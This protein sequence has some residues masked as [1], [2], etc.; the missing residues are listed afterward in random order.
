MR[1]ARTLGYRTVAVYSATPMPERRMWPWPTRRYASAPHPRAESYLNVA[2]ILDAARRTGADAVHPGYGFLSENATFAQACV[3]AGLVFIGPPP[4][5]IAAMG[6]KAGAK[7]RM[8]AAGV[9]TV[10]GY[11]GDDQGD[12]R[13]MPEAETL[14]FP[15]LVKAVAG[16]GGRG[17]RLVRASTELQPGIDGARREALSAFGD[18][19]LML[20]RLIPEGR[21]IEIQVFADAHGHAV[22]LGERD[23]T[24]Q[25]RRQKVIEEAPSP[26]VTAAMRETMGRDAVAAALAV[27]YRG[28]GTVE[29]I[30]DADLKH[31]FLEMNTR[32]QVEHPV[33]E[34]ITGLDLVEWQLRVAA[35]EAL[36]LRQEQIRFDGHAIEARLYAEDPYAGFAPQTGA[37]LHFRPAD[38]LRPGIRIDAGIVEGG[39]VTP[40]YDPMLAKVVA[41]GRNRDDAIRRLIAALEDAPLLGV[42]NNGR[43][44][45][46]LL[47]HERFRSATMHT[48]LLDEWACE[49]TSRSCSARSRRR[50]TGN[51]AAALF[52]GPAR[53]AR[54]QRCGLRPDA[55][56]RRRNAKSSSAPALRVR[57][58][59]GAIA[60]HGRLR[61]TQ[62]GITRHATLHR[63]GDTLH[64]ARD[65]AVF[66]FREA[67]PLPA[68]DNR[69]DPA[70]ARA[71][72]AGTVARLEVGAGDTVI[73]GQTL[74]V[75]E[76]MKMEMR[77]TARAAGTVAAVRVLAGSQVEAGAILI[78][79]DIEGSPMPAHDKAILT[80]ALTGVLTDPTQHPVPVTPEADGRL[81]ARGLQCRRQHH[82]CASAPAG[83]LGKGHLPSWDP[84]VAA[85]I[86]DAIRAACPGVIINL[87]TGVIGADISGPAACIRRVKPE[88]A[89]CNAG[90]LNYLKLRDDGR[91]AWPPMVFDNPVEKVK[92]F[93]DVMH[94]TGT[95]PEFECFDVGIVRSVAM[96]QK[97]GMTHHAD[98][99]FVM[100]VASGMPADADLLQLLLR[101]I[102]PG[103]HWQTTL[104]GRAEIWPLHQ[105]T[106]ELG[107]MLRTGP[108]RHASYLPD[109]SRATG[110]GAL[111]EALAAC[112]RNA[113]R[114]VASPAEARRWPC[115]AA[116]TPFA[117]N[118]PIGKHRLWPHP[119]AVTDLAADGSACSMLWF[120]A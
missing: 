104:I 116:L 108:R 115:A 33:T 40:W 31:H 92:A 13:L 84:E 37:V 17:M 70:I 80:C 4:E 81:G 55:G 76:A 59:N 61:Y 117:Q 67:S 12:E 107:G 14:G 57:R 19:T 15:L 16:G 118:S 100:G 20:E 85:E 21:H 1:T 49:R 23:C 78:E 111:I 62:D 46:D 54:G 3:D 91:W 47:D 74:A 119:P 50:P 63:D 83:S 2:A 98:Y 113:G 64:L 99:N 41:H 75:I 95:R 66:V 105:R 88:I 106:A 56:L 27:G 39:R 71:S 32:L 36:P 65:A 69:N 5:A 120:A 103:S 10:P 93:L 44:L 30:V 102:E 86:V 48:T 89:A 51:L 38:A 97:A 29:F 72:V 114:E 58:S 87:T 68:A 82:A 60:A 112:A 90:T 79:L 42:A 110:N 18:G 26:I 24:A 101:W 73:A 9:P 45:R 28:A 11:L 6:D 53:L 43:F 25:R 52:A 35:G 22:H 8:I 7:R 96:Y 94:E 34:M 77:V 109:G